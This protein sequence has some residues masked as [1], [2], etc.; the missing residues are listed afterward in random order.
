MFVSWFMKVSLGLVGF[1]T[2]LGFT[3]FYCVLLGFTGFYRVI[4]VLT[5]LYWI[6][7]GF[8]GFYWELWSLVFTDAGKSETDR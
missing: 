3:G 4:L 2:L 5:G 7:L 1:W 6:L 8:I